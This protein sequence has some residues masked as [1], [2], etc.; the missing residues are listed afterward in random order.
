M[1]DKIVQVLRSIGRPADVKDIRKRVG[2]SLTG[3]QIYQRMRKDDRVKIIDE[4]EDPNDRLRYV[5]EEGNTDKN[6]G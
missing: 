1:N 4:R 2:Y 5:L 6:K 3:S